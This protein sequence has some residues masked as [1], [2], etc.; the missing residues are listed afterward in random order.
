MPTSPIHAALRHATAAVHHALEAEAGIEAGLRRLVDR[1]GV[2]RR[3]HALH[4]AVEAAVAPWTAALEAA[5]F[6]APGR[7][8]LIRRDLAVLG[9]PA[10]R[11]DG[12]AAPLA[13][14]GEALGWLYVSEGSMLGGRAMR[15]A[16]TADGISLAGLDFLD[17]CGDD[18]GPRWRSLLQ[19]L[20]DAAASGQASS[21]DILQGAGDAF[22]LACRLLLPDRLDESADGPRR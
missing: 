22:A 6:P 14:F 3:L 7:S 19:L 12:G 15:R 4:R 2:M 1:P 11:A 13:S 9:H 16:M 17:P 8:G 20:E 5:G 18:T 10:P 21:A